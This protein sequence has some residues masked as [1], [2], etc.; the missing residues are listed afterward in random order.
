LENVTRNNLRSFDF[1]EPSVTEYNSL[2]GKGLLQLI[3]NGTSL[4]FLDETDGSV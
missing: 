4:E 1:K 3:Y 2:Q